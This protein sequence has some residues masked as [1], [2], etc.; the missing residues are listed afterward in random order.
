[1]ENKGRC[2]IL[3]L[4]SRKEPREGGMLM[5]IEEAVEESSLGRQL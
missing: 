2:K 3:L 5:M 4:M 1:M